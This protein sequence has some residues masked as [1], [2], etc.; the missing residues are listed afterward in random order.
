MHSPDKPKWEH[1][2]EEEY[3]KMVQY[4]VFDPVPKSLVPNN[5]KLLSTKWVMKKKPNGTF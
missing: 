3:K 5:S 4:G 2:I 1:A